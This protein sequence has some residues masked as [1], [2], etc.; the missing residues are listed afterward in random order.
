V[1]HHAADQLDVEVAL[2][3]RALAGLAHEGEAL[4]QDVA[5]RLAG[6][7]PLAQRGVALLELLV[8]V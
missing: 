8:G 4:G 5:E 2:P 7:V 1:Q 6:Q 3:E